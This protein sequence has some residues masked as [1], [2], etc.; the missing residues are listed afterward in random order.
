MPVRGE[1]LRC[2]HRPCHAYAKLWP[3]V[4]HIAW[5]LLC[6]QPSADLVHDICVEITLSSP[7]FRHDCAYSTWMYATVSHHV[8]NWTRNERRQRNLLHAIEQ[9]WSPAMAPRP[10]ETEERFALVEALRAGIASLS[11][12]QRA[13]LILV[14]C[15]SWSPREVA[16]FLH[17]TP[18]AVR[19]NVHRARV[20]LRRRLEAEK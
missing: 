11:K 18:T 4:E 6:E 1:G 12:A 3:K 5:A 15:E 17:T 13:C 2:A 8:D 16:E 7:R 19:M 9:A 10:D 20:Q 14:R